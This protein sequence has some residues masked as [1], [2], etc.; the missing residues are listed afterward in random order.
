LKAASNGQTI[1]FDKDL[2]NEIFISSVRPKCRAYPQDQ[3]SALT[4]TS[5]ADF[6]GSRRGLTFMI[7][8]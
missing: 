6:L 8:A 5:L 7:D 1:G 4:V 3:W 2:G